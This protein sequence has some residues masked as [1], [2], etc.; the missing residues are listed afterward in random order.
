VKNG[1]IKHG[2]SDNID[3]IITKNALTYHHHF[4]SGVINEMM[5]SVHEIMGLKLVT[6]IPT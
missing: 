2:I 1:I 4:T 6:F 3:K 5:Y